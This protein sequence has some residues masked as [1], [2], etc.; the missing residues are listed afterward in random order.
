MKLVFIADAFVDQILGGGEINNDELIKIF[1]ADG[2][3]VK[4]I[5]SPL[6][7]KDFI[8]NNDNFIIAN[9]VGLSAQVKNA[10]QT[11]KYIIYEH[12]HKYL[13]QRNP[14][15][16]EDFLAPRQEIINYEFYKNARAILCQTSFHKNIVEN[17]LKLDNIKSVGGNLWNADSLDLM[18]SLSSL[19][20]GSKCSIMDSP[21]A[22][23]N[24]D[25]AIKYCIGSNQ[26]YELIR[27][28]D[29]HSFLKK[30]GANEKFV[31][32]PKTPE[33]LSR[34]IVEARMMGVVVITNKLVGATKEEWF[35]LKGKELIDYM[36]RK[37]KN[38]AEMVLEFLGEKK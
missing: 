16:Y 12:D 34:V 30:L 14:A 8:D 25:E 13:R 11:K 9:F 6:V 22:H 19:Y 31:F 37:K 29:Y 4:T 3:E 2:H 21:I 20:K 35:S 24:T 36:R 1:R 17:N 26:E 5:N 27:D 28:N 38:I 23:K 7:S 10:L 15:L 33:T 32:F 18:E